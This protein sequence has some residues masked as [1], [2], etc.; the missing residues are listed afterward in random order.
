MSQI[1]EQL[2][3]DERPKRIRLVVL[4]CIAVVSTVLALRQQRSPGDDPVPL[5]AFGCILAAV[6]SLLR[7]GPPVLVGLAAMAGFPIGAMI[8]L[9]LHGGHTMLPFEFFCYALYAAAGVVVAM[10]GS[11]VSRLSER[12]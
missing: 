3:V 12:S 10:I 9:I 1:T 5:L 11:R 7:L 2:H 8:D 6:T 4:V